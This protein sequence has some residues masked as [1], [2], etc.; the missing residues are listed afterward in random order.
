[1]G[2]T[3]SSPYFSMENN[4]K[5]IGITGGIGSGKSTISKFIEERGFIVI[6]SDS[7]AK[8]LYIENQDLKSELIKEFGQQFYLPDGNINKSFIENIIFGEDDESKI[9]LNKLNRL[10]HPLVIQSNIDEID[11][12]VE[13][14]EKTIFVE[15]A[16]IF[17]IG[18]EDAYD[19]IISV[20]ANPE[21][22]LKRAIS[23]TGASKEQIEKRIKSQLS[24]EEKKKKADFVINN[25]GTLEELKKATNFIIDLIE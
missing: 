11:Q 9:K 8:S 4:V 24:P 13:D 23:R 10:V 7:K 12:L 2:Y 22:A 1:M 17:E 14:G 16:L 15:S 25:N 6:N 21:I 20:Y 3:Q 18:M 19:Y 5:I